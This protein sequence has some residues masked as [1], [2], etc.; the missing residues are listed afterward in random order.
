M[1]MSTLSSDE[2][3]NTNK[4]LINMSW[5]PM[6]CKLKSGRIDT[7]TIQFCRYVCKTLFQFTLYINDKIKNN[8]YCKHNQSPWAKKKLDHLITL[9]E[10]QKSKFANW[11]QKRKFAGSDLNQKRKFVCK[12]LFSKTQICK[13]RSVKNANLQDKICQK[14]KFARQEVSKTQNCEA[15][16]VKKDKFARQKVSKITNL[17]YDLQGFC[18]FLHGCKSNQ[19]DDLIYYRR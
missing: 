8:C 7:K 16:S 19:A 2:T 13:T 11:P 6:N 12:K 17:Q 18:S 5:K 4:T 15:K 14:R 3:V 1:Q 9:P 10:C